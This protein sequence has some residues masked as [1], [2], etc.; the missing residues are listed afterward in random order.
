MA[1]L[2]LLSTRI[3][4]IVSRVLRGQFGSTLKMQRARKVRGFPTRG[5]RGEAGTV[6][7]C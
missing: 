6:V 5:D 4:A 2:P 1:P 7:L 3:W